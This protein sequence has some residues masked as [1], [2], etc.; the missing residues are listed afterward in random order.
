MEDK[1]QIFKKG[2]KTF[3]YSSFFFPKNVKEDVS[4]LYA[5]VRLV[6]DFVDSVPALR[7][8]FFNFKNLYYEDL[9]G[10]P[11]NVLV[12]D[13]FVTLQKKYMFKQEWIDAFLLAMESDLNIQ[14]MQMMKDAEDYMYGSASVVGF[15]MCRILGIKEEA[16]PYANKLGQAFQYINFIRDIAED[17]TLNRQYLPNE[18]LKKHNLA[19]LSFD[20]IKQNQENFNKFIRAEL[21]YFYKLID[22]AKVGFKF[23]PKRYRIPIE[24]ATNLYIYTARIIYKNPSIIYQVKVKPSK[25]RIFYE[26]LKVIFKN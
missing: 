15:M 7:E 6:D 20:Y 1:N 18:N 17:N 5:F 25:T 8:E 11:S 21:D 24:I 19:N 3:F 26:A 4:A 16:Y 2:S 23:I 9:K 12:I 22:Q 14:K 13:E 10:K